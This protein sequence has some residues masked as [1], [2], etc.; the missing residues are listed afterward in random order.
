LN[1]DDL[2]GPGKLGSRWA[3]WFNIASRSAGFISKRFDGK[4][5]VNFTENDPSSTNSFNAV[6]ELAGYYENRELAAPLRRI[7]VGRTYCQSV[8]HDEQPWVVAKQGGRRRKTSG[9]SAQR[10]LNNVSPAG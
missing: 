7:R 3:R 1:L 4:F 6:K 2:A 10:A 5:W 8:R 9:Q